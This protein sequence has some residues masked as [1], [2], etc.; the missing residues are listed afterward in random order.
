MRVPSHTSTQVLH[1]PWNSRWSLF[2]SEG[3]VQ[4]I[5]RR[6]FFFRFA[7]E[8]DFPSFWKS[9]WV[10]SGKKILRVSLAKSHQWDHQSW[11]AHKVRYFSETYGRQ[12]R[13][14]F[15]NK[16]TKQK[17][18]EMVRGG[19]TFSSGFVNNVKGQ[20]PRERCPTISWLKSSPK[21]WKM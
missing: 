18:N 12:T 15:L 9:H 5:G 2:L 8:A 1:K 11:Q 7:K 14:L 3:T 6:V 20:T 4:Y 19:K 21:L 10:F 17:P 16:K 13:T